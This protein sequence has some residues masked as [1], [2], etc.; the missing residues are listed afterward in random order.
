MLTGR[1]TAI[2]SDSVYLLADYAASTRAI[3][4]TFIRALQQSDGRDR[5]RGVRRGALCTGVVSLAAIGVA[6]YT[7]THSKDAIIPSTRFVV[8]LGV[9]LT[10]VGAGIGAVAAPEK[11]SDRVSVD[12]AARRLEPQ[13]L[14][15]GVRWEF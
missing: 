14:R 3:A 10:G 5:W 9:L 12:G 4:T 2:D 6:V 15:V 13:A 11:W 7:D 8:P 1:I